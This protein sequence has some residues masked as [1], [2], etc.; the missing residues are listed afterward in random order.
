MPPGK[1]RLG[2]EWGRRG[3]L[4]SSDWAD[5][6]LSLRRYLEDA[7]FG[8]RAALLFWCLCAVPTSLIA[9]ETAGKT[10]EP[11]DVLVSASRLLGAPAASAWHS[12]EFQIEAQRSADVLD[13]LRFAPGLFVTQPGAAG[14]V[15]EV[16]LRGAESNFTAVLVD[17]VKVNDPTNRR[18]GGFDFSTLNSEEIER[19]EIVRGPLS[20]VHGSDAMAGVIN[21]VTRRPTDRWVSRLQAAGGSEGEHRMFA[22]VSGPFS[23]A[24]RAG[25]QGSYVDFGHP[26]EGSS[27]RIGTVKMDLDFKPSADTAVRAGLRYA[28]RQRRAFPDASGGPLYAMSRETE[29][30]DAS[31][32]MAWLEATHT[33]SPAWMMT[34]SGTV[35]DRQEE[36][37]S[38]AI[39]AGV[40]DAL[41]AAISD[42]RLHRSQFTFA[43]VVT[44]NP[45]LEL[46][47]GID[48]QWETGRRDGRL[49]LGF[50]TLP[51]NFDADRLTRAVYAEGK[52]EPVSGLE[53]YAA[54]RIDEA[55]DA[56]R[57]SGRFS[58][59]YQHA[60]SDALLRAS[61]SNGHKRPSFYAL[62]DTLVGNPALD[63]ETSRTLEIA[64]E[65]SF[66]EHRWS[67]GATVFRS[68]YEDLIDFDFE[69]LHLVNRSAVRIEGLELSL[70]MRPLDALTVSMYGT[71]SA[72]ELRDGESGLLN[73]PRNYGG[74]RAE[75]AGWTAWRVQANAQFVGQR[76]GSSVPT[77]PRA[78]RGYERLDIAI[79]RQLNAPAV[80][81]I[82]ASNILDEHSQEAVGFPAAGFQL[83]LGATLT[84]Q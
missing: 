9:Q 39:A 59:S 49:D 30:A 17:G 33:L 14:G 46:G 58:V 40:F 8:A 11:E 56:S 54:T 42:T 62:G 28:D 31:E 64:A 78:L 32:V 35:L 83:R 18:G 38:P 74:V 71:T 48:L 37:V 76:T 26:V 81:Y 69:T 25:I 75:W 66:S 77:G 79:S 4:N 65:K 24:A 21:V 43:N 80:L 84:L 15:A 7:G 36:V 34:A 70:T 12:D 68:W 29:Q 52:Y 55:D 57:G 82:A 5:D 67:L 73:R 2:D 3:N 16:F 60:P 53:L 72:A 44:L 51:S 19:I 23:A 63:I 45:S 27:R 1:N 13:L 50:M 6:L 22:S 61:W 20:A 10:A 41:P 47:G